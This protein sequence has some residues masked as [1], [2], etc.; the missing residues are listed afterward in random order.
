MIQLKKLY[1]KA[2]LYMNQILPV[3]AAKTHTTDI[4]TNVTVDK[5]QFPCLV[6]DF[7]WIL[8]SLIMM[9][10]SWHHLFAGKLTCQF[11]ECQRILKIFRNF[12]KLDNRPSLNSKLSFL[13]ATTFGLTARRNKLRI[14]IT[15]LLSEMVKF[16]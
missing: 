6:E 2:T 14:S 4:L 5:A 1:E 15:R 11:L 16:E 13:V 10:S 7:K 8:H 12:E 9:S 3:N